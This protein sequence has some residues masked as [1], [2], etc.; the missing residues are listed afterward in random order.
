MTRV[1][2][3]MVKK[4]HQ[5]PLQALLV[6]VRNVQTRL[7]QTKKKSIRQILKK[8]KNIRNTFIYFLGLDVSRQVDITA[9]RQ[10]LVLSKIS[11][12]L[13]NT[14]FKLQFDPF[15]FVVQSDGKKTREWF[16]RGKN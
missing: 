2:V 8:K 1:F 11:I 4:A 5:A 14:T 15:E 3:G 10:W 12:D 6:L 7:K 13:E 9:P 16:Y